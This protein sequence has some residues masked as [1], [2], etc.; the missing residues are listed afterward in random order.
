MTDRWRTG[1]LAICICPHMHGSSG[2]RRLSQR[3]V[4]ST[5]WS[6][7]AYSWTTGHSLHPDTPIICAASVPGPREPFS[8][9]ARRWQ[10][11][12]SLSSF[13]GR[14]A[15]HCTTSQC[16]MLG[17]SVFDHWQRSVFGGELENRRKCFGHL[18][19]CS[20]RLHH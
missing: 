11:A 18:S 13:A 12:N 10:H 4:F 7:S 19:E 1:I 3:A 5:R 15:L 16:P 14:G 17:D 6:L 9:P 8:R 20:L 2:L